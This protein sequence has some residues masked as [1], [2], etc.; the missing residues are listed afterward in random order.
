[1]QADDGLICYYSLALHKDV[2]SMSNNL[3]EYCFLL[4]TTNLCAIVTDTEFLVICNGSS[5]WEKLVTDDQ[6]SNN[7]LFVLY[8]LQSPSLYSTHIIVV[9]IL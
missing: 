4:A 5:M 3:P 9:Q 7:E 1:M 6:C 2:V 8:L